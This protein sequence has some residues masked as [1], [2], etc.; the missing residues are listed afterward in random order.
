[1]INIGYYST[2]PWNGNVFFDWK[3]P[4][5][6]IFQL[7]IPERNVHSL[8]QHNIYASLTNKCR[9]LIS[10]VGYIS[11]TNFHVI[12]S[13]LRY[14]GVI[15]AEYCIS[16]KFCSVTRIDLIHNVICL[17]YKFAMALI[18]HYTL[19]IIDWH[20]WWSQGVLWFVSFYIR[21]S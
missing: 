13:V 21:S 14:Q 4:D 6:C 8:H 15:T 1:M 18:L 3:M 9:M 17:R 12:G 5:E 11:L 16:S 2:P 10:S 20:C 19:N 7:N